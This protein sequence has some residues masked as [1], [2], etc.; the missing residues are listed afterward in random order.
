MPSASH[1][2]AAYHPFDFPEPAMTS[3]EL[4]QALS[5]EPFRTFRLHFGSGRVVEIEN[6]SLVV[7]SDTGRTA[8][9]LKPNS[10]AFSVIDILLVESI[11]FEDPAGNGTPRTTNGR[12]QG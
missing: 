3:A 4:R 9:A 12:P 2:H 7:V 10:D 6:P 5:T 8:V 1:P 11:E